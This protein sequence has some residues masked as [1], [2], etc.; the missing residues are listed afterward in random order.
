MKT[1]SQLLLTFLLNAVWQIALIAAL[2]SLGAWLLRRSA[3]RFQHWLWVAALCLSLLVPVVTVVRAFPESPAAINEVTYERDLENP[4]SVSQIPV[5]FERTPADL[6]FQ[7]NS[8]LALFVFTAFGI[9]V[10]YRSF[11][12][13]QAW[14]VTRR[15]RDAAV[16][17]VGDETV[18]AIIRECARRLCCS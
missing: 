11:R 12:L 16:K 4:V 7:L 14:F 3:M 6:S 1:S 15:V 13:M 18:E 8:N 17:L 10:L 9:V 2:A 5:S